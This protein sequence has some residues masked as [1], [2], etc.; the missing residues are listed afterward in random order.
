MISRLP[1][2]ISPNPLLSS[3]I[4]IRFSSTLSSDETLSAIRP[5]FNKEFPNFKKRTFPLDK[6]NNPELDYAAQ[7]ILSNDDYLIFIDKNVIAF[8]NLGDY[9]LWDNYYP[10]LERNLKILSDSIPITEIIRVGL[11]YVSFFDTVDKLSDSFNFNF[12]S[13]LIGYKLE[14][15]LFRTQLYS[16]NVTILL[17]LVKN[18][19][20]TRNELVERGSLIDIDISQ[21]INLPS[22]IENSLFSIIKN[23][24]DEEKKLFF[25]LLKEDFL[26]KFTCEY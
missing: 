25:S 18:A 16:D 8:E 20:I 1:K 4:E 17:H 26:K 5:K 2:K 13:P 10:M 3:T 23:L 11:R 22:K 14:N 9:H 19:E 24:H 7:Y 6:E 15:E 12:D 21:S